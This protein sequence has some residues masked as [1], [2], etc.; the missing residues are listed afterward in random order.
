MNCF[1]NVPHFIIDFDH[2]PDIIDDLYVIR[3][4]SRV[5]SVLNLSINSPEFVNIADLAIESNID[6]QFI[7][8]D[9]IINGLSTNPFSE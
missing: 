4:D 8:I 5:I 1:P 2:I 6:L 7:L 3:S 9:F